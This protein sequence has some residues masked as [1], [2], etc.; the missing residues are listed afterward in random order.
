M[1]AAL[2]QLRNEGFQGL[3]EDVARLSPLGHETSICL[4]VMP[5]RCPTA[6]PVVSCDRSMT[7]ISQP[8]RRSVL[9]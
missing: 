4:A 8:M 5:S 2:N 6:L 3:D 7:P 9:T 1:D